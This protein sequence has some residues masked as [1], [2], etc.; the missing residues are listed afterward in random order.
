MSSGTATATRWQNVAE[1]VRTLMGA[2]RRTQGDL[3]RAIGLPDAS[4]VSKALNGKRKWT[5][6]EIADMAEFFGVEVAVFYREPG[7]LWADGV[8]RSRCDWGDD[9]AMPA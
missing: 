2:Q 7:E 1:I 5:M 6:D 3:A 9:L 8:V 4:A